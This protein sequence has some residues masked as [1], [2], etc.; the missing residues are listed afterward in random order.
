MQTVLR[1]QVENVMV[2]ANGHVKLVDF[3]LAC[4]FDAEEMPLSPMGSLIYMA[5]ELLTHNV[6]G[7]HTD[8]WAMGILAHELMTLRTPWSSLD[9]KQIIKQEIQKARVMP[10]RRLSVR[11]GMFI[12]RLLTHDPKKRLGSANDQDVCAAPLFKYVD[13]EAM[14]RGETEPAFKPSA[15]NSVPKDREAALEM[16]LNGASRFEATHDWSCGLHQ[17]DARPKFVP[18]TGGV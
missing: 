15:V 9:E 18:C 17:I 7:R 13:W 3:G 14:A 16:Y 10:P 4:A 11:A 8:W 1:A 6:G 2:D 12:A 5:P